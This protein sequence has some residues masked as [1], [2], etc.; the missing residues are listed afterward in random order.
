M[1][2]A[3]L[4]AQ[5]RVQGRDAADTV[6]CRNELIRVLR[7]LARFDEAEALAREN[8]ETARRVREPAPER[9][10]VALA[11]V[12]WAVRRQGRLEEAERLYRDALD[13]LQRSA[14]DQAGWALLGLAACE[15]A[16]GAVDEA[17]RLLREARDRWD[18]RGNSEQVSVCLSLLLDL[19]IRSGR[20]EEALA[21]AEA[22]LGRAQRLGR[23][24]ARD[25]R[26]RL[27]VIERYA[28]VFEEAGRPE[29]GRRFRV[30]ADYLRKAIAEREA[31]R[32]ATLER[33]GGRGADPEPEDDL[34]PAGPVLQDW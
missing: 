20:R 23:Q 13:L 28:R 31:E 25:E 14:P 15:E 8:L 12:A 32:A 33:T 2:R 9:E 21:L 4:A 29:Q 34:D 18:R 26:L 19:Y 3:R 10:G 27:R 6:N 5:V 7:R 22:Q 17:E 1:I 30:R 11:T 24:S 16:K